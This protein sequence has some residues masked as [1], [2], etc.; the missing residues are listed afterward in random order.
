M[1]PAG[2]GKTGIS[3]SIILIRWRERRV[4]QPVLS[5]SPVQVLPKRRRLAG[6]L[7]IASPRRA[8][9]RAPASALVS[10]RHESTL[11]VCKISSAHGEAMAPARQGREC[12]IGP[13]CGEISAPGRGGQTGPRRLRRLRPYGMVRRYPCRRSSGVEHAL[14]KGGVES[15]ILSGGT[16]PCSRRA[17]GVAQVQKKIPRRGR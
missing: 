13:S 12:P 4:A 3:R 5:L 2:P 11:P 8:C 9:A 17:A 1:R 15:S 7:E 14:G 10:R 16:I 6:T